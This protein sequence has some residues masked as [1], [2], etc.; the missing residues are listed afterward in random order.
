[1]GKP[2][3]L[4]SHWKKVWKFFWKDDSIWS[5]IVNIIVAFLIIRFIVYPIL[6]LVLGTGFPIVAVISE[7]MDHTPAPICIELNER[8]ECVKYSKVEGALCGSPFKL[9]EFKHSYD[10]WWNVCGGGYI[11]LD[12]TKEQFKTFH[13]KNGF[14]KGDVIIL[15]RANSENIRLG[16]I[17]V[18]QGTKVQPIIHRV[19]RVWEENGE[20][21]YQTKGD[22]NNGSIQG[23]YGE[24]KI[25]Q[26]RVF[27][28][29]V[30][31]IPY[32][33]W[34]KILFVDA[35]KPLGITIER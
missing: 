6:G 18:F 3:V 23:T 33:G 9:A 8:N 21:F 13:F 26:D 22:H 32:L 28:K 10:N 24:T 31:R 12:I 34:M 20:Q 11:E 15:W 2:R 5:W 25:S 19:V 27:G 35:V 30:L 14:D 17:L 7:S 4:L 16:D 1:M 29:G